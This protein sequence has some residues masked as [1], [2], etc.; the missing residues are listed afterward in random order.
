MGMAVAPSLR[1]DTARRS[2]VFLYDKASGGSGFASAAERDLAGLLRATAERLECPAACTG[3]CPE[4]VLRRDL[5]FGTQMDRARA[6]SV[7]RADILPRLDLP[8]ALRLFGTETR[9]ITRPLA[10]WLDRQIGSGALDRLRLFLTDPPARWDVAEWP[11]MQV[12]EAARRA[13]VPVAIVL[14]TADVQKLE[15]SHKLDL[16]RLVTR[17]EA[18]LH[19]ADALPIAGE[20]AVLAEARLDGTDIA[21]ASPD[22]EA[23]HVDRHWGEGARALTVRGPCAPPQISNPLS[24][25]KVTAYGE[26]TAAQSDVTTELDGPVGKFGHGLWKIAKGL[27]PQVFATDATLEAVCAAAGSATARAR[28]PT[29]STISA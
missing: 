19:L 13:S 28:A 23:A 26:G 8:V 11:G 16:V 10:A 22:P 29:S 2:S 4:C 24:L 17:A 18:T 3:G 7:L 27:R 1:P 12:A 14:R 21:I 9:A 15:M 20:A 25:S 6:L 5:Q